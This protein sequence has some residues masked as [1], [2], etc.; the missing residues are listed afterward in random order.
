VV[1]FR[2]IKAHED[3]GRKEMTDQK[4]KE[5]ERNKINEKS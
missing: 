1:E 3:H 4:A 5:A 2:W